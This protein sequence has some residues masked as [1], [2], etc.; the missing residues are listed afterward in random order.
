MAT[1]ASGQEAAG[2]QISLPPSGQSLE[3]FASNQSPMQRPANACYSKVLG[4]K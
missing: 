1:V 2:Y 4:V 3:T